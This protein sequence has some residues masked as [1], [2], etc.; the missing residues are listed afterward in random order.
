MGRLRFD[1]FSQP[2]SFCR[3]QAVIEMTSIFGSDKA[4]RN[5]VEQHGKRPYAAVVKAPR[6]FE[7]DADWLVFRETQT[8]ARMKTVDEVDLKFLRAA[9]QS[10]QLL[11]ILARIR[12]APAFS[13]IRIVLGRIEI[14]IHAARCAE[15]EYGPAMRHAPHRAEEAF[16]NAAAGECLCFH[17]VAPIWHR[18][19]CVTTIA[20]QYRYLCV[21]SMQSEVHARAFASCRTDLDGWFAGR[22]VAWC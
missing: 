18:A 7:Q 2:S 14:S 1:Y 21:G 22:G 19:G 3:G 17:H 10:E 13:M 4:R 5:V 6:F 11:P 16:D 20:C 8:L 15:F 9:N 12:T